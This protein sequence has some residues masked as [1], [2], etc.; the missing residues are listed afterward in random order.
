[1]LTDEDP[2]FITIFSHPLDHMRFP[3]CGN[4]LHGVNIGPSIAREP[5]F[6]HLTPLVSSLSQEIES[7]SGQ[8]TETLAIPDS[9]LIRT[10]NGIL[11]SRSNATQIVG[12]PE[13]SYSKGQLQISALTQSS[14]SGSVILQTMRAD[15][16]IV[17]ETITKLPKSATLEKSYAALVPTDEHKNIRLVL[18]MA[19]QDS[20]SSIGRTDFQL[21][22]ILDRTKESIPV[23]VYTSQRQLESTVIHVKRPIDFAEDTDSQSSLVTK[24]K[25]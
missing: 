6:L 12:V 25:R 13:F 9:N 24:R 8:D 16:K 14:T 17:A 4:F 21:P 11:T 1:M 3:N 20:Y 10:P 23:Q 5:V 7:Y 18:N 2:Q 19:L 15:G 22:A